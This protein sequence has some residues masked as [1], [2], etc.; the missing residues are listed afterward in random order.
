[1]PGRA[2]GIVSPELLFCPLSPVKQR[3]W[4]YV[5]TCIIKMCNELCR[6]LSIHTNIFP[7]TCS[8]FN[9]PVCTLGRTGSIRQNSQSNSVTVERPRGDSPCP[10]PSRPVTRAGKVLH[11]YFQCFQDDS[12]QDQTTDPPIPFGLQGSAGSRNPVKI[13]WGPLEF[14]FVSSKVPKLKLLQRNI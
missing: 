6:C 4:I 8:S 11:H 12:A 5:G 1:M 3:A 9:F 14:Y 2:E 7:S 10:I 13:P